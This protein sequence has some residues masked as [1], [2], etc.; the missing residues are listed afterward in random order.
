MLQNAKERHVKFLNGLLAASNEEILHFG[1]RKMLAEG[2][3]RSLEFDRDNASP[4]E[5]SSLNTCT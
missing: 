4:C 2:V 3:L 5:F 1:E